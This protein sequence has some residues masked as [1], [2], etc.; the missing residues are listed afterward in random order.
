MGRV[1]RALAS[2]Y[3][4]SGRPLDE[5]VDH[6]R[7]AVSLLE[8]TED[9]FWLSQALYA[10]SF[11]CIF[12]GD[13]ESALEATTRLEALSDAT[14]NRRAQ[15]NAAMIAGFGHAMRGDVETGIELCER[16][17]ELSPDD[18]ETAYVLACLGRARWE[19]GDIARAVSTFEQA[20]QLADQR[21]SLQFRAWFRTMLGETYLLNGATDKATG[22]GRKALEVSTDTQFLLGIGL[23]KLLLGRIASAEGNLAEAEQHL[24]AAL[25]IFTSLGARFD[26]GRTHLDLAA[27]A[28]A[29]GNQ[30]TT[31]AN[32]RQ[33]HDL[34]SALGIPRYVERVERYCD[35]FGVSVAV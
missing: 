28:H 27:L 35:D 8:R 7:Q 3:L 30:E 14:G 2:E 17:L 21:R 23:S 9:S 31:A 29:E 33:A 10:L 25:R 11:C 20:V 26:Q 1:H 24:N 22:V 5:A 18:Y 6:G 4:F 13:F 19:A 15:A 34:F 32:L 12:A 16:A